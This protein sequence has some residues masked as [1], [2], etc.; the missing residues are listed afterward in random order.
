MAKILPKEI[1][2]NVVWY[3]GP[4]GRELRVI[5]PKECFH[6]IF[7]AYPTPQQSYLIQPSSPPFDVDNKWTGRG[8]MIMINSEG[9]LGRSRQRF[10]KVSFKVN[11]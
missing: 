7:P 5:R 8:A 10:I 4:V 1:L 6:L 3:P 2:I 11:P 9:N